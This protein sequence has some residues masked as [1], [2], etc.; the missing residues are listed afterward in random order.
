MKPRAQF[1]ESVCDC[2]SS[3]LGEKQLRTGAILSPLALVPSLRRI[4]W[5]CEHPT[6]ASSCPVA[7]AKSAATTNA[8]AVCIAVKEETHAE[9]PLSIRGAGR[10]VEVSK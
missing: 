7:N 6:H 2:D 5:W 9:A 4:S 3:A 10:C 1:K 8:A